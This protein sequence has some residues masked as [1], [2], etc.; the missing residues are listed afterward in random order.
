MMST[1]PGIYCLDLPPSMAI[2]HPWFHTSLLKLAG[3]KPAGLP[4]PED[5]SYEFEAILQINKHR[6]HAKVKW[7]GYDSSQN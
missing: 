4:A 1:G 7:M 6:N 3:P 5:D 2:V